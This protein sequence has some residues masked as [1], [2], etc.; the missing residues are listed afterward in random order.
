MRRIQFPFNAVVALAIMTAAC[1]SGGSI[2]TSTSAPTGGTSP[3]TGATAP[4]ST[5]GGPATTVTQAPR[6]DRLQVVM[7]WQYHEPIGSVSPI[8]VDPAVRLHAARDYLDLRTALMSVEGSRAVIAPSSTTL[9]DLAALAGGTDDRMLTLSAV[10]AEQLTDQQ[11]DQILA[12]FFDVPAR[13]YATYPRLAALRDRHRDG[14]PLDVRDLRDLQVLFNLAW[15]D[16]DHVTDPAIAAIAERGRSF[17]EIDQTFVVTAQ[18]AAAAAALTAFADL[19]T[20]GVAELA[21]MTDGAAIAPL[22][23]DNW[24]AASVSPGA[25]LPP[26]QFLEQ[27]DGLAVIR[28]GLDAVEEL[29]GIRPTGM[30]PG[31]GV[32]SD[33]ALRLMS[34]NAVRWTITGETTLARSLGLRAFRSDDGLVG[35]PEDLYRPWPTAGGPVLFAADEVLGRLIA[36]EYASFGAIPAAID[37]VGRLEDIAASVDRPAVVTIVVDGSQPWEHYANGGS[38]FLAETMQRI[39]GSPVLEMTTPTAYLDTFGTSAESLDR[40]WPGG[41]TSAALDTWIGDSEEALAWNLLWRIRLDLRLLSREGV[42]PSEEIFE[43]FDAMHLAESGDWFRWFGADADSGNDRAVDETFR[44]LLGVVY[45]RLAQPRADILGVPLIESRPAPLQDWSSSDAELQLEWTDDGAFVTL[46]VSPRIVGFDVW[47]DGVGPQERRVSIDGEPLGITARNLYRWSSIAPRTIGVHEVPAFGVT[48]SDRVATVAATFDGA[49]VS[50]IIPT[51]DLGDIEPGD[52]VRVRV[53]PVDSAGRAAGL[54]PTSGPAQI[55]AWVTPLATIVDPLGDDHGI[56]SA[57]YPQD[58]RFTAGAFDISETS[59][60]IAGNELVVRMTLAADLSNPFE[61]SSG[62][63]LQ[64][65]DLAFDTDPGEGTGRRTFPDGRNVA[66]E[67]G[68]GFEA[69][70]TIDG[71]GARLRNVDNG[72]GLEGPDELA[73]R[74]D[75]RMG[76]ITVR[77]PVA[78]IGDGDP[79]DWGFA[80]TVAA[81]DPSETTGIRPLTPRGGQWNGGG[82]TPDASHP[83][84]YDVLWPQPFVQEGMLAGFRPAESTGNLGP[85]DFGTVPLVLMNR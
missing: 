84:M 39:A 75:A 57:T 62:L 42:V 35:D 78:S 85:D 50:F 24:V 74:I 20:S 26:N 11:I 73:M 22:L 6:R 33:T 49:S 2:T 80:A 3:T 23:I 60:G 64:V 68:N 53:A 5:S 38:S 47:V 52:P 58:R 13:A 15:L 77:I 18:R 46:D 44:D 71:D 55:A 67:A 10:P 25:E 59:I 14:L 56:G 51:D 37:L 19:A 82:V 83:M 8:D 16:L 79:S 72:G 28:R 66:L 45:D 69:V 1:T 48:E 12:T 17:G 36:E 29:A 76:S 4:T 30:L 9:S 40:V 43:A 65:I 54:L 21:A 31:G 81:A 27:T 61:V 70:I 41:L 34:D 32:I 7:V 63:G